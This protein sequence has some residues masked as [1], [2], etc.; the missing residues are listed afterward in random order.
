MPKK[1]S[2]FTFISFAAHGL[3]TD[4]AVVL[5]EYQRLN[6]YKYDNVFNVIFTVLE[7]FSGR[8]FCGFALIFG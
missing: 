2:S 1:H 5:R 4:P 6:N 8:N 7:T 3:I